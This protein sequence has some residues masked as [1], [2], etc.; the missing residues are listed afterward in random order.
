MH[1]VNHFP[2][3]VRKN[4]HLF[5]MSYA[6]ELNKMGDK[7]FMDFLVFTQKSIKRKCTLLCFTNARCLGVCG[8]LYKVKKHGFLRRM[9][10]LE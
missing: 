9:L 2:N 3:F 1:I 4:D 8:T 7:F 10:G 6:C 5:S